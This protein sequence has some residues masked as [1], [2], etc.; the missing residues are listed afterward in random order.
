MGT[1]VP[2]LTKDGIYESKYYYTNNIFAQYDNEMPNCTCYAWGRFYEISDVYPTNLP[3]VDGGKWYPQAVNDGYYKV[4]DTPALGAVACYASTV[5]GAGHVGVVEVIHP[6][7]SFELSQ[8]GYHRPILPYPP[9]TKNY[10]WIDT[11][12]GSTKK[13]AWMGNYDF[14]GF[15]YNPHQP[16]PPQDPDHPG[17]TATRVKGKT[18]FNNKWAYLITAKMKGRI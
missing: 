14:Q 4:G 3:R 5:G 17:G 16:T 9:D 2:R 10:F 13:A 12:D 18:H 6:D 8:S 7:G 15:I 1:F 11:C